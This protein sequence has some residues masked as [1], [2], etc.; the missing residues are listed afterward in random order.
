MCVAS[1]H[2]AQDDHQYV[3]DDYLE[4]LT[5]HFP[6]AEITGMCYHSLFM[7]HGETNPELHVYWAST[8]PTEPHTKPHNLIILHLEKL[9]YV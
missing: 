7:P 3:D 4:L 5:L 8:L 1:F 9:T 6:D 2:I